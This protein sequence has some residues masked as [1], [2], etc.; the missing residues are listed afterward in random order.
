[1]E[2]YR[3]YYSFLWRYIKGRIMAP[4]EFMEMARS[5]L[6]KSESDD[7]IEIRQNSLSR[8][9]LS[10]EVLWKYWRIFI[11][12][13]PTYWHCW[14]EGKAQDQ[15]LNYYGITIILNEDIPA[16]VHVLNRCLQEREVVNL[17]RF[18]K[19]VYRSGNDIVH[20][21]I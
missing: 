19:R 6:P 13:Y 12:D 4:H 1:M 14:Y 7:L 11:S 17:K 21:G 3:T 8:I 5:K 15:H 20:M 9:C 16:F 18:V 2:W 10:D